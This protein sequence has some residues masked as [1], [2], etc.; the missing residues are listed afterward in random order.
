MSNKLTIEQVEAAIK[1]V[2][3]LKVGKKSTVCVM[4]LHNGFEIIASSSCVSPEY[5]DQNIG[6]A[7]SRE[8]ATEKI[9]ELLGFNLQ[10]SLFESEAVKDVSR[11]DH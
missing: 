7:L 10:Q 6:E 5:Y 11:T 2:E 1:D 4:T 9:W 8:R 3:F